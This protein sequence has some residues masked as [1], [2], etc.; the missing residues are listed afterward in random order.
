MQTWSGHGDECGKVCFC[1]RVWVVPEIGDDE[2][3]K[4]REMESCW[5]THCR[6]YCYCSMIYK[7]IL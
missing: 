4:G 3:K 1:D 2:G 6:R 5:K 7:G